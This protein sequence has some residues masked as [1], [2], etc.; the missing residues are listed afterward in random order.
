MDGPPSDDIGA[1]GPEQRRK[2]LA[3]LLRQKAQQQPQPPPA[4]QPRERR[5]PLSSAQH[6]LWVLNRIGA[7]GTSYNIVAYFPVR[8]VLDVAALERAVQQL[9]ERQD[10][11]RTT[12]EAVGPGAAVQVIAPTS[13]LNVNHV[14][15]SSFREDEALA[16][17]RE[18]VAHHEVTP[19]DLAR[20]PLLRVELARVAADHH[21]VILAIHH[22]ISDGWSIG[23]MA[24]ELGELYSAAVEGR[25]TNLPDLPSQ[26]AD[27]AQ[28][29]SRWLEGEESRRQFEY[30]TKRLEGL[31]PLQMPLDYRRP[32]EQMFQ[33]AQ[34]ELTLS[35]ELS[36][37]L[38]ALAVRREK[39]MFMLFYAAYIALLARVSGQGDFAIGSPIANR[40]R[41]EVEN[42]I[43]FFANMLVM[44]ADVS[45]DPTFDALLERAG[46]IAMEAYTNQD[47]PFEK[48]VDR[49]APQR[50]PGRNPLF[51]VALAVQNQHFE[52]PP[53]SGVE[54]GELSVPG[55]TVG[56]LGVATQRT[57][58]DLE[59]HLWDRPAGVRGTLVFDTALFR[60]G[61][62]EHLLQSFV[63]VLE[64]VVRD[65][66]LRVSE[67]PLASPKQLE[68]LELWQSNPA[69]YPRDASVHEMFERQVA[70]RPDAPALLAGDAVWTYAELNA[71]ANRVAHHLAAIGVRRGDFV[72]LMMPR[73]M[74]AIAAMLGVLKAG[75]IYVPLDPNYPPQRL[76]FMLDDADPAAL[77]TTS[78][79]RD[80]VT[81]FDHPIVC[82]DE[83]PEPEA[84]LANPAI[85]VGGGDAA[86][87][88]YT[89]GST[90]T[91]KGV[92]VPHRAINRLVLNT[93][94]ALL[95]PDATLLQMAPMSFDAA[96]FEI[97]GALLNGGRC[98]LYPGTMPTP[99]DIGDAVRRY[100]V[101]TL[102]LTTALFNTVIDESPQAFATLQ[103]LLFGGE[104]ASV[105]HVRRALSEL[106]GLRISNIY[107]PTEVTTYALHHP[108]CPPLHERQGTI[109]IGRVIRNTEA[110]VV[111]TLGRHV[112]PGVPGELQLGG[113]GVAI[114]YHRRDELTAERF[115]TAGDGSRWYRTGD[116]VRWLDDG[117]IEFLG[118]LDGQVKVR[119]FRIELA[120]VEAALLRC[121]GV[122]QACVIAAG[123]GAARRL[124]AYV[125]ASN[126]D[127]DAAK[128]RTSM[129]AL[130]PEF[131]IPAQFVHLAALPLNANGKVDKAALPSPEQP[132][133]TTSVDPAAPS[134]EVEQRIMQ[135]WREVLKIDQLGVTDNFFDVGGQSLS[136]VRV[137]EQLRRSLAPQLPVVDLFQYPT[138]RS[139]A[140]HLGRLESTP[141]DAGAN[142]T[143]AKERAMRQR[144]AMQGR[145]AVAAEA[146]RT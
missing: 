130:V 66:S 115:V 63:T 67:L 80:G 38:R 62:I 12:I 109:P 36:D 75:G 102:F 8:G 65:P 70:R 34:G 138:V 107:G 45:D 117:T 95:G 43:G 140:E 18:R 112:P 60:R 33:G 132:R 51:Q 76:R 56:G 77:L 111:D 118:R 141:G 41:V 35:K 113:D 53:M 32:S 78:S 104:A 21:V 2:L 106:P 73:S 69:E 82:V 135:I 52:A 9:V 72:A 119:G 87:M 30:W 103:Q 42:V 134:G 79:L 99:T 145:Q 5:V 29:Q 129:R 58:F 92:L 54:V 108:V 128:L 123:D 23:L 121:N 46:A 93:D 37:R 142:V 27:H 1:L 74:Q 68:Q 3:R 40:N 19:F 26:F 24:R 133:P 14:D 64:A 85:P 98:A 90:G 101:T 120:E 89:S 91:S 11:L 25:K 55:F 31:P 127:A 6:G 44:R 97:W 126:H 88:M 10:A 86:Y 146:P 137:H 94:Y 71:R 47:C 49:L 84:E 4:G 122:K 83:L 114:G 48:L 96:T 22:V 61:T 59:M 143:A 131:M 15:F 105:G 144:Q 39:S 81:A 57:R 139:L 136:L 50:D 100:G 116:L 20:G 13:A 110:R 125:V 16:R 124:V 28:W 7:Q 17:V